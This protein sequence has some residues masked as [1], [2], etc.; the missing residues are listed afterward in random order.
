M[1]TG[2]S[3]PNGAPAPK[4]V[5]LELIQ[6]PGNVTRLLLLMEEKIVQER[7]RRKGNVIFIHANQVDILS[8]NLH[9]MYITFPDSWTGQCVKDSSERVLPEINSW[10]FPSMTRSKCIAACLSSGFSFAGVQVGHEC[11]CGHVAPPADVIVPLS[12]CNLDCPGD[13]TEKCGG[14]WRMNVFETRQ[15]I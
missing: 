10:H 6:D 7:R 2:G 14:V 5:E 11:W 3:G 13:S 15:G 1:V 8:F 12:E 9:H 4:P